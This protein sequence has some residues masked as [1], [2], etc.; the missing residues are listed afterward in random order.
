M[1]SRQTGLLVFLITIPGW[2]TLMRAGQMA[3][4]WAHN[5]EIP[6]SNPGLRNLAVM[7]A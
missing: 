4:R 6:G 2:V 7:L 1:P 5:P 3:S